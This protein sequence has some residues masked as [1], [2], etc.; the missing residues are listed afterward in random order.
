[1]T[2]CLVDWATAETK[3]GQRK[4][5]KEMYRAHPDI[6]LTLPK[7]FS[8]LDPFYQG[9]MQSLSNT[10]PQRQRTFLQFTCSPGSRLKTSSYRPQW[11]G[12]SGRKEAI[13]RWG[14]GGV[15]RKRLTSVLCV[16]S[17][18]TAVS[19]SVEHKSHQGELSGPAGKNQKGS[20]PAQKH[21][22]TTSSCTVF[23]ISWL[24]LGNIIN[25]FRLLTWVLVQIPK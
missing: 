1:M 18:A 17:V 3:T 21:F 8:S 5:D 23:V 7:A 13:K 9:H 19:G 12:K 15:H 2:R 20:L 6:F 16:L 4:W 11:R 14:G 10:T 25:F 24:Q 22:C